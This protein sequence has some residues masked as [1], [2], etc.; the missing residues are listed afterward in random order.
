MAFIT[1]RPVCFM[2]NPV[3]WGNEGVGGK[4]LSPG[5]VPI[6][7]SKRFEAVQSV[8][9]IENKKKCPICHNGSSRVRRTIYDDRYGYKGQFHLLQ[10]SSCGHLFLDATFTADELNELYTY[11]YPRSQFNLTD[12]R[13]LKVTRGIRS[14]LEGMHAHPFFWIPPKVKILD[15]GCGFGESLAY[16]KDRGC[17]AHG[18]EVDENILRVAEKYGLLAKCG[19]F[20]PENYQ[21]QYF[22]YVTMEQVIEHVSDPV[23]TLRDILTVLKP[24]GTVIFSSPNPYSWASCIFGKKWLNWHTPYHLHLFSKKSICLAAEKAGFT[25]CKIQTLTPSIWIY[26]QLIHF[27]TWPRHGIPSSFWVPNLKLQWPARIKFFNAILW[28]LYRHRIFHVFT[29]FFDGIGIGDNYV[30]V[31]KVTKQEK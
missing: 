17:E 14:W 18:V 22:D 27:L 16:H 25:F 6:F 19:L 24:E 26:F 7:W 30:V 9:N 3:L 1:A 20:S 21:K 31:L 2:F 12:F 4:G 11:F 23:H 10:C 29:R 15:I 28:L 8:M 13:P 5:T